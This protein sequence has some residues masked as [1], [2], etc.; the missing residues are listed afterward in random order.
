MKSWN[1]RKAL[2]A[3]VSSRA[4]VTALRLALVFSNLLSSID[5]NKFYAVISN[6]RKDEPS[7]LALGKQAASKDAC[8]GTSAAVGLLNVFGEAL[9]AQKAGP[10]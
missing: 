4:M 2:S 9:N 5:P 3:I 10:A 7:L 8:R 6:A 1:P